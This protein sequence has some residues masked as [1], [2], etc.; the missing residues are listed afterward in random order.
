MFVPQNFISNYKR[1]DNFQL[2]YHENRKSYPPAG[3]CPSEG[4]LQEILREMEDPQSNGYIH[5]DRFY[6][7]MTKIFMEHRWEILNTANPHTVR[8]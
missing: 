6:T 1:L 7:I 2:T 5:I 3:F 4:E 8:I